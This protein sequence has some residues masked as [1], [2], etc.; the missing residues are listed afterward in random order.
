[1]PEQKEN[2]STAATWQDHHS[3]RR[4]H[5]LMTEKLAD[6]IPALGANAN[7]ADCDDIL[8]PAKLFSPYSNWTWVRRGI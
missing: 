4:G 2:A 8:A 1:M 3:G 6:T 7:V 5:Q